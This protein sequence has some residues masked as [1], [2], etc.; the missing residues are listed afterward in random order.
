M[1]PD[2]GG[3]LDV[4]LGASYRV[5]FTTRRRE[6]MDYSVVL[7]VEEDGVEQT[8]RVY[9]GAHGVNELHRYTKPGGKQPAERFHGGTLGEG[10]RAAIDQVRATYAEM[11]ESWRRG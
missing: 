3:V 2:F 7:T 5:E 10:M 1:T 11:I 8:V 4:A 6:V 9:D